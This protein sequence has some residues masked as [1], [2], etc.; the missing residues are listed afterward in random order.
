MIKIIAPAQRHPTNRP[1]PAFH[2][3]WAESQGPLFANTGKL[4]RYVQHLTLPEAYGA[5]PAPTGA[6]RAWQPR[7]TSSSTGRR[8]PRW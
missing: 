5:D 8:R 2:R 7:S 4:R 6:R 1:L 3:Y